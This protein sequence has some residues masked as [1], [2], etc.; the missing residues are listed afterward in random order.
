MVFLLNS[1][2][3]C[4]YICDN[5]ILRKSTNAIS[6]LQLPITDYLTGSC[7]DK[8][9]RVTSVIGLKVV[10]VRDHT[11]DYEEYLCCSPFFEQKQYIVRDYALNRAGLS[12]MQLEKHNAMVKNAQITQEQLP[13]SP[14]IIRSEFTALPTQED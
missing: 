14:N 5:S 12:P 3:L 10:E 8:T 6:S 13:F 4:D 2:E 1:N 11:E 9:H 7:A